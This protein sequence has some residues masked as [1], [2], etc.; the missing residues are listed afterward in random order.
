M[1]QALSEA[2]LALFPARGA[3]G[4]GARVNADGGGR[5]DGRAVSYR[6]QQTLRSPGLENR[7]QLSWGALFRGDP[8]PLLVLAPPLMFLLSSHHMNRGAGVRGEAG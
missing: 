1:Q 3:G 7:R 5:A 4:R 6:A 8:A 2:L